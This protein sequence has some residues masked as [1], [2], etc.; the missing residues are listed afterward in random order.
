[1]IAS[2]A[3]FAQA[4]GYPTKP[5][6]L[7]AGFAAGGPTD[8]AAPAFPGLGYVWVLNHRAKPELLLRGPAMPAPPTWRLAGRAVRRCS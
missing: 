2:G 5:V 7:V 6:K 8:V 3:C 1:L 4:V